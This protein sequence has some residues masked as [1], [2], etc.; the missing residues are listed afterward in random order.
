MKSK[1]NGR[2]AV[3]AFASVVI[4]F[5]FNTNNSPA[6][7]SNIH[8]TTTNGMGVNNPDQ[9]TSRGPV[10]NVRNTGAKGDGITDDT[11]AIQTAIDDVAGTGGTVIVPDGTYLIDA[12]SHLNLKSHMIFRMTSGAILK[13]IPNASE[14][15]CIVNIENASNVKVIGGTVQGERDKHQGT[16]G[17]WGFGIALR[18]SNNVVIEGVTAKDC[19]GDGFYIAGNAKN[20]IFNAVVADNNRR[21]GMSIVNAE[22]VLINNSIFK[23]TQGRAPGAGIDIE[24]NTGRTVRNVQLLNSQFLNNAGYGIVLWLN[25]KFPN[26]YLENVTIDGNIIADN[27]AVASQGIVIWC[28]TP[29][30]ITNNILRNNY[31]NSILLDSSSGGFITGNTISNTRTDTGAGVGGIYIRDATEGRP[32]ATNNTVTGNTVTGHSQNIRIGVGNIIKSNTVGTI[33]LS[34]APYSVTESG[35]TA[36]ITATRIGSGPGYGAATVHYATSNGTATAGSD[37]TATSGTLSWA[38]GDVA[39]K[40]FT[41]PISNDVLIEGSETLNITLK[42]FVGALPGNHKSAVITINE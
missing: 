19:W 9:A 41:I 32:A 34:V 28:P 21:Q 31:K 7:T 13:A 18:G 27:G 12:I 37:Y 29:H 1:S 6:R 2:L 20:S 42:D 14:V 33:S 39:D 23:N 11:K 10:V 15:H 17:Q 5:C 3:F 8:V 30:R 25:T 26:T 22:G 35:G 36:T 16:T 4:Y 40:T 24:P 38:D